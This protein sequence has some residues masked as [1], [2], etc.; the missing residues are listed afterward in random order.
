MLPAC[1]SEK[2]LGGMVVPGI[3]S[4]MIR[5]ISV[6]LVPRRNRPRCNSRPGTMSPFGPWQ[7]AQLD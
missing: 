4:W 7:P 1:G 5:M 6:S 3:P 2:L